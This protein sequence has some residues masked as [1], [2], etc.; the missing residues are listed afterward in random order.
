M[1]GIEGPTIPVDAL[2]GANARRLRRESATFRIVAKCEPLDD[3]RASM[4]SCVGRAEPSVVPGAAA[5]AS[6]E[7]NGDSAQPLR[8]RDGERAFLDRLRDDVRDGQSATL[9]LR[10]EAGVGKTALLQYVV[11]RAAP[12]FR[13]VGVAGLESEMELAYA[14]LHQLCLPMLGELD[15]LPVPQRSALSVALG[16]SG[17]IQPDRFLVGLATL[18]LLA[19]AAEQRPL[20]CVVD[21]AQWLDDVSGQVLGFVARRLAAESVAMIFAV[22]EWRDHR[23]FVGM[24]EI[25]IGGLNDAD[26]RALLATV[27]P[28]RLDERVRDRIIAETGGNPLAL[29][30]LP[31]GLS[32]AELAGGFA[33][34]DAGGVAAQIEDVYS[35]RMRGLPAQTQQLM[36]LAAADA[37]GEPTTVWLAAEILGIPVDAAV[38]AANEELLEIGTRVRFRHPLVRSAAYRSVSPDE[39][40]AAHRAL[41]AA[42]D[43]ETDPERRAWHRAHAAGG[44]DDEVASELEHCAGVAQTRGGFAAAAA[45]LEW[46]ADLTPGSTARVERRLAAAQAKL[47]AGA[48]D[49]AR[50]LLTEAESEAGEEVIRARI[51]LLRGAVA[52]ASNAGGEAPLRL[53]NAARR[54]QPVD[55]VLARRTYLDAWGAALFAGHLAAPGGDLVEVSRAALAA[56]RPPDSMGPFDEML[57]GLATL[58]IEDRATAAPLL[59]SAVSALLSTD[60]PAADWLHWGVLASASAVTLWDF[61]SWYATSSRQCDLARDLGALAMLSIALNGQAMIAAWSG[62]FEVAAAVV[63]EDN[64]IKQA[65]GSQLAPYGAMLVAAYQGRTEEA[66]TL[67][68]TTLADSVARGEGLGV[69]LA[70]WTA[71]ILNNGVGSYAAALEMASPASTEIPG[72]YISTWMLPERIEAAVRCEQPDV[73]AAALEE[74]LDSAN[75]SLSDWGLGVEARSRA[76]LG[77]GATA[78]SLYREAIDRLGRTQIRTELARA[79]LLFGEWLRREN[80]RDDAREQLRTAHDMFV[81]M[82][83]DGFANRTRRELVAAGDHSRLRHVES[84]DELTEQEAHIARLARD[85]RT[86]PEIAAELYISARTVEWHLRKVF[87]KLGISSRRSLKEA[88]PGRALSAQY[89]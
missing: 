37:V 45:L 51:E 42:I 54:L 7:M 62:D 78:E 40:R 5:V 12:D 73:A 59:Q 20:L 44:P 36:L 67:I 63:A 47:Q 80:R 84:R 38:P 30:E 26:A 57:D 2:D 68:A 52:A 43:P 41:A 13:V 65:I 35:K 39:R 85:G 60:V 77:N 58:I 55:L 1:L 56:P 32:T 83:A 3:D 82:A 33:L 8:G 79:H 25:V 29:L 18:N 53:L 27:V 66:S 50:A 15:G 46:A 70:R 72:L 21:D 75:S 64:A 4:P 61:E 49:A 16:M 17:G 23:P 34:P 31:R 11:E 71:A 48:F 28:V 87:V 88:M 81:L 74:F 10:G 14:G 19:Q 24:H 69:D 22:R 76:L 89:S 9:V 6:A 86:N